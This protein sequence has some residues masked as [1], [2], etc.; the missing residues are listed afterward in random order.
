M[1]GGGSGGY[2]MVWVWS[3]KRCGTAGLVKNK[4]KDGIYER[5]VE[6]SEG[7]LGFIV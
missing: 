2:G 6:Y 7:G 3:Y 4:K 1:D 5:L